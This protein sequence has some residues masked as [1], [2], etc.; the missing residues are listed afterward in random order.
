MDSEKS[1][2]NQRALVLQGGGSIGAY[3]AGV[4]NV[5]YHWIQKDIQDK[6]DENIFDIVAGTSI[7]AANGAILVSFVQQNK[8]W[9]GA[10]TK[11]LQFWDNLASVPDLYHWWPFRNYWALPWSENFWINTWDY[12]NK[13]NSQSA[14]AEAARRYYSAKECILHG[15]P[16]CFQNHKESMTIVFLIILACPVMYGMFMTTSH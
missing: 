1:I 15:P 4:F 14:T 11:L 10:F 8:T 5:L 3:E 13:S 2:P 12:R 16:M 7:G 6:K 9:E